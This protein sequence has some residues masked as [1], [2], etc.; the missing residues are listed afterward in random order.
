MKQDWFLVAILAVVSSLVITALVL[1]FVRQDTGGYGPDDS[2]EGVVRNYVIAIHNEDFEMAYGYLQDG[3]DKP[4]YQE[5]RQAFFEDRNNFAKVSVKI[6]G[7]E[8]TDQNAFIKL[9][10]THGST[11]PFEGVWSNN[12]SALLVLQ[13]GDWK[14]KAMAYPYW[15]WNW[16]QAP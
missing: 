6:M 11:S 1:F 2:P 7:T 9:T 15:G 3:D 10:L 13:N 8:I 5:F 4:D 14:L 16:Y 12:D